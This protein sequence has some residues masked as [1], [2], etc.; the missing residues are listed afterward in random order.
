MGEIF[1]R[2]YLTTFN[3]ATKEISFY[4][5]Q[6]EQANKNSSMISSNGLDSI[7]IIKISTE[8][9]I[10]IIL[11]Y[12]IFVLYKNYRKSI[13]IVSNELEDRELID[14]SN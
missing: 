6:V 14:K 8:I 10:G 5:N 1:L 7:K 12:G 13:K 4:K 3:Y 9:L 11:F 2:K